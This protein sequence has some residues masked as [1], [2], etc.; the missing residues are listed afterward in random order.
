MINSTFAQSLER[1]GYKVSVF[2]TAG[3]AAD[4]IVGQCSGKTVGIGG[5]VTVRQMGLYER[6]KENNTVYWHWYPKE[7]QTQDDV[8]KQAMDT[9]IYISS[10]NGASENGELVNIDGTGN[11]L[12]STVY[13]HEK[14]FFIIGNNKVTPDLASAIERAKNIAA[15]LNAKRLGS[16]TPC[17]VTGRCSDCKGTTR[18]CKATLVFT[19]M[20]TGSEYEVVLVDEPLGY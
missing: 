5:S 15:P 14:V 18:I 6:L 10:V 8:R 17:A 4:Y 13:G 1:L 9:Q 16:K 7:G 12:A 11:R 20:P 3:E 2:G 19:A